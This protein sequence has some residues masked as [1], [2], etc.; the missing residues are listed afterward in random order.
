MWELRGEVVQLLC[1]LLQMTYVHY[2]DNLD[3]DLNDLQHWPDSWTDE[4][5][6][7]QHLLHRRGY[8]LGMQLCQTYPKDEIDHHQLR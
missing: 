1:L 6:T 7:E 8:L 3:Q 4:T 5:I 2:F